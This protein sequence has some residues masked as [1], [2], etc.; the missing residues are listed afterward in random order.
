MKCTIVWEA[1][2]DGKSRVFTS[3]QKLTDHH[4]SISLSLK[5]KVSETDMRLLESAGAAA[6]KFFT[7]LGEVSELRD[8]FVLHSRGFTLGCEEGKWPDLEVHICQALMTAY[9]FDGIIIKQKK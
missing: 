8:T 7:E 2:P 6:A 4:G 3:D 9:G 1:S 5:R